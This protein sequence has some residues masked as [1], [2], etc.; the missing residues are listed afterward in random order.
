MVRSRLLLAGL[1]LLPAPATLVA[2]APASAQGTVNESPNAS[3]RINPRSPAVDQ[4]TR[5]NASKSIDADGTIAFYTWDYGDGTTKTET[6]P[7]SSHTYRRPGLYT[8]TLTVTDDLGCSAASSYVDCNRP[9]RSRA[10]KPVTVRDTGV[11]KPRTKVPS[12]QVQS[13]PRIRIGLS[14]GAREDV[15]VVATGF[16]RIEGKRRRIALRRVDV[17]TSAMTTATLRS[18]LANRRSNRRVRRAIRSGSSVIAT[19]LVKFTDAAGNQV[20]Q[21]RQVLLV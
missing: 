7:V 5:F 18:V 10:S 3:F 12:T 14:V 9:S 20:T 4:R 16:V 13:G 21:T 17:T 2:P 19:L 11:D 6:D 15:K 8:A 1:L